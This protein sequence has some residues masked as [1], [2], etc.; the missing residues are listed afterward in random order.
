MKTVFKDE[1]IW[2]VNSEDEIISNSGYDSIKELSEGLACVRKQSKY[3]YV[4]ENG[5]EII[6][7]IFD[8]AGKFIEGITSAKLNGKLVL[9]DKDG[10]LVKQLD[11]DDVWDFH[12]GYAIVKAKNKYGFINKKGEEI[13]SPIYDEVKNFEKEGIASVKIDNNWFNLNKFGQKTKRRF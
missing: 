5:K 9:I 7:L 12:E 2:V 13:I 8:D 6:P 11:Y 4:D 10:I 1:L 3:G